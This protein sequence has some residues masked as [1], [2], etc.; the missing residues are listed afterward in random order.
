MI[1]G[2]GRLKV[3][4]TIFSSRES[5]AHVVANPTTARLLNT[6]TGQRFV[7]TTSLSGHAIESAPPAA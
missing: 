6:S 4:R 3:Q 7:L 1:I 5:L 2:R